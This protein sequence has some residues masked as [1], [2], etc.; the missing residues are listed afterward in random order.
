MP[1]VRFS[2]MPT[3]VLTWRNTRALV[4]LQR[5]YITQPSTFTPLGRERINIGEKY[6]LKIGVFSVEL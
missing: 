6:C 5:Y 1:I 3:L 2:W 4:W